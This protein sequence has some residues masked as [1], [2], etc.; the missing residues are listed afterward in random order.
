MTVVEMRTV[1]LVLVGSSGV[2]KTALRGKVNF[3]SAAA[4]DPGPADPAC[5]TLR[6]AFSAVIERQSGLTSFQ[7]LYHIQQIRKTRSRYRSGSIIHV[8]AFISSPG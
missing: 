6:D 5:S 2:G 1:K 3:N 7:K 4:G 8:T